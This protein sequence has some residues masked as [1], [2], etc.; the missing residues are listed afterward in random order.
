VNAEELLNSAL[1][2]S[3]Q[4]VTE[5]KRKTLIGNAVAISPT[6]CLTA[7]H[8]KARIG[9]AI[10]LHSYSGEMFRGTVV[11]NV[12]EPELVDIAVIE[13]NTGQQFTHFTPVS[14]YSVR[15]LDVVYVAGLKV[16][17]RD[18]AMPAIYESK[19]NIIEPGENN[20][21]FQSSYVSFDSSSVVVRQ[22]GN[23]L[24]VIGVHV[25]S[26]DNTTAT[27]PVERAKDTEDSAGHES[28]SI[29]LASLSSNI[30]G[31]SA[32]TMICEIARVPELIA[33]F[34]ERGLL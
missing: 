3:F 12:F 6:L 26:H 34:R 10:I 17:I 1:R 22:V 14:A 27:P 7:L 24:R 25:A 28:V 5:G 8:G 29:A 19:V 18:E 13:L 11:K 21:L 16:N 30:H 20:A 2:I 15:L 4:K 31:H 32:Y 33:F 9:H 23:D